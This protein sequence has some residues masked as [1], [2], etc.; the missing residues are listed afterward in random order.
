MA[1]LWA[2]RIL[3]ALGALHLVVTGAQ[4][5]RYLDEW[6]TGALWGLP[7]DEFVHPG[8][9]VGAFWFVLG[10][11]A[12]P[13]LLLGVLVAHLARRRVA[14][15]RSVGWLLGAWCLVAAAILEPTPMLLGLVPAVLLIRAPRAPRATA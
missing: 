11:F 9:A 5:T 14:V 10:S 15:P 6:F 2:G 4:N 3:V 7:R 13:M 12:V 1:A 8:G